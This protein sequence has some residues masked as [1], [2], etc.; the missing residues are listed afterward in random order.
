MSDILNSWQYDWP[1]TSVSDFVAFAMVDGEKCPIL[2]V[3]IRTSLSSIFQIECLI[4]TSDFLKDDLV[5]NQEKIVITLFDGFKSAGGAE[6]LKDGEKLSKQIEGILTSMSFEGSGLT[7]IGEADDDSDDPQ[8]EFESDDEEDASLSA[9]VANAARDFFTKKPKSKKTLGKKSTSANKKLYSITLNP[10]T[11][12]ATLQKKTLVYT[13]LDGH[14][15]NTPQYVV[16]TT[17]KP[18]ETA[19]PK[20]LPEQCSNVAESITQYCETDFEFITRLIEESNSFFY[21]DFS[22]K[23][24]VLTALSADVVAGS[25]NIKAQKNTLFLSTNIHSDLNF[26]E[27]S[28]IETN[29]SALPKSFNSNESKLSVKRSDCLAEQEKEETNNKGYVKFKCVSTSYKLFAGDSFKVKA[30]GSNVMEATTIFNNKSFLIERAVLDL[31]YDMNIGWYVK[32]E[33]EGVVFDNGAPQYRL[34]RRTKSPEVLG[35]HKACVCGDINNRVYVNKSGHIRVR[36]LDWGIKAVSKGSN[37]GGASF[38]GQ[39]GVQ[40]PLKPSAPG[41]ISGNVVTLY[42]ADQDRSTDKKYVSQKDSDHDESK[43]WNINYPS[44]DNKDQHISG[45]IPVSQWLSSGDDYGNYCFPRVGQYVLVSFTDG[46]PDDPIVV[47]SYYSKENTFPYANQGSPSQKKASDSPLNNKGASK[48]DA[49]L[50]SKGMKS[51]KGSGDSNFIADKYEGCTVPQMESFYSKDIDSSAGNFILRHFS[52]DQ[53]G[54]TNR[55]G[56]NS[57]SFFNERYKEALH[58]STTNY[59]FLQSRNTINLEAPMLLREVAGIKSTY[60]AGD[61][62]SIIAGNSTTHHGNNRFTYFQSGGAQLADYIRNAGAN[63]LT[64][65]IAGLLDNT[66]TLETYVQTI[67]GGVPALNVDVQVM[68]IGSKY[69]YAVAG[70]YHIILG[71]NGGAGVF[72]IKCDSFNVNTYWYQILVNGYSNMRFAES[73]SLYGNR[74]E[75]TL[76]YNLHVHNTMN[77]EVRYG[78]RLHCNTFNFGVDA[79]ASCSIGGVDFIMKNGELTIAAKALRLLSGEINIG[80]GEPFLAVKKEDITERKAGRD[81]RGGYR[82]KLYERW[83]KFDS[84]NGFPTRNNLD[85]GIYPDG[86]PQATSFTA[87]AQSSIQMNSSGVFIGSHGDL[88]L[89]AQ[90]KVEIGAKVTVDV[91]AGMV[92]KV[93]AGAKVDINGPVVS[94]NPIGESPSIIAPFKIKTHVG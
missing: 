16:E 91:V 39:E 28:S 69:L 54:K 26:N 51:V 31:S 56:W 35:S 9:D 57:I 72:S 45:W 5:F 7:L 71:G 68:E 85:V 25:I 87:T 18:Y 10:I 67:L 79:W 48:K 66:A 43:V 58:L 38:G 27:V 17:L 63:N 86:I 11:W 37:N 64:R 19:L 94:L 61:Q 33:L 42:K 40:K 13:S 44:K 52:Y 41:D 24:P 84:L 78:Y 34:Q 2:N 70:N 46:N 14:T 65:D 32:N 4:L 3:K 21:Y 22:E 60:V 36:F 6:N 50:K 75:C 80:V 77:H 49:G 82:A 92:L 89:S 20:G 81:S 93:G 8:S 12:N 62:F 47:G 23:A 53:E 1:F 73:Y 59:M 76:T 15:D 29:V 88:K 30:S 83:C 90:K 74:V 55:A